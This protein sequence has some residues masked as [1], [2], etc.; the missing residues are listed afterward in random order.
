[1]EFDPDLAAAIAESP[2]DAMRERLAEAVAARLL[3]E[4]ADRPS[5]RTFSHALVRST[6]VDELSTNKRIRLRRRIGEAVEG[7]PSASLAE[8]AHH[9]CEAATAGGAERA[10]R[11]ACEAGTL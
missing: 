9:F 2:E 8:L 11:Y 5:R 1:L 4:V 3:D 7:R 6:L 10:V